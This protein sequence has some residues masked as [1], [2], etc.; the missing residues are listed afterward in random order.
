VCVCVC[1]NNDDCDFCISAYVAYEYT[2]D[3]GTGN[4]D[5]VTKRCS[6]S[7]PGDGTGLSQKTWFINPVKNLQGKG[8]QYSY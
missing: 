5:S 2:L 6:G 3:S 7:V 1:V 8:R 4:C